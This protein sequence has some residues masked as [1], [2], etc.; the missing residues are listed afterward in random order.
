MAGDP[1]NAIESAEV[2]SRKRLVEL[3][4]AGKTE[5]CITASPLCPVCSGLPPHLRQ[6]LSDLSF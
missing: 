3:D 2:E 5:F 1:I 4:N 6:L